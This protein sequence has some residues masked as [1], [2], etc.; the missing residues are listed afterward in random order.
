[1]GTRSQNPRKKDP[2]SGQR[3]RHAPAAS[4]SCP[5]RVG[6]MLRSF[7]VMPRPRRRLARS[8][9]ISANYEHIPEL[10][11][12][13]EHIPKLS[14]NFERIPKLSANFERFGGGR[15][16]IGG[17]RGRSAGQCGAP[18]RRPRRRLVRSDA[19]SANFEYI[20]ELSANF[21]HFGGRCG[22]GRGLCGG[23]A[24]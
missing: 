11:A 8:D 6:V 19:I 3:R 7:G 16:R 20:P 4:A 1:M 18:L 17:G 10:S 5:G 2:P 14:A 15:R 13:F 24:G 21:D 12:N 23:D 22:E 9:A